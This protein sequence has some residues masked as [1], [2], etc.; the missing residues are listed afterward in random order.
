MLAAFYEDAVR[1]K[2]WHEADSQREGSPDK[3]SL[4]ICVIKVDKSYNVSQD[5]NLP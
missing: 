3:I 1:F 2:T 4:R 5:S